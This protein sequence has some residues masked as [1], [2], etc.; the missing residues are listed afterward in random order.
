M[1]SQNDLEKLLSEYPGR[2]LMLHDGYDGF[3]YGCPLDP[4]ISALILQ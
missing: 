4:F 2:R 1:I 3:S